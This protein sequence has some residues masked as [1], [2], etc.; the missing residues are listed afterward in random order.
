MSRKPV[1]WVVGGLV[2]GLLVGAGV[3]WFLARAAFADLSATAR[4]LT[5]RGFAVTSSG[6]YRYLELPWAAKVAKARADSGDAYDKGAYEMEAVV[7]AAGWRVASSE[8]LANGETYRVAGP[9]ASG[10]ILIAPAHDGSGTTANVTLT[11]AGSNASIAA[12]AGA[13]AVFGAV[14]GGVIGRR[15]RPRT[16]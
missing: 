1:A 2:L 15:R 5:P 7:D 4:A 3:G 9:G 10:I 14:L 13:G 12:I 16:R 11:P 8:L 6:P